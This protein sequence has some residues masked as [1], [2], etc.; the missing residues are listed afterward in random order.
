LLL[1]DTL[2]RLAGTDEPVG[3][4][5]YDGE[6]AVGWVSGS[7]WRSCRRLAN[8]VV[9]RGGSDEPG[10]WA[11][12][13]FF[14]RTGRRRLNIADALLAATCDF[15]HWPASEFEADAELRR[16][17][18]L[19]EA[20]HATLAAVIDTHPALSRAAVTT[21]DSLAPPHTPNSTFPSSRSPSASTNTAP[22]S[23]CRAAAWL[24]WLSN[25]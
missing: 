5:A 17:K 11:V 22:W 14:V 10:R 20:P 21:P 25:Y 13:C 3:L 24:R 8:A 2:R 18:A 12:P 15:S 19:R 7:P 6:A 9:G 1:S 16:C 23:R 4:L